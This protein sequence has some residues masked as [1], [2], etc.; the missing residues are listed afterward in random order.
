MFSTWVVNKRALHTGK[1]LEHIKWAA[2]AVA[3]NETHVPSLLTF[4]SHRR[5]CPTDPVVASSMP[6]VIASSMPN[7]LAPVH[8]P[9]ACTY[10]CPST[11][12]LSS[13]VWMDE[14]LPPQQR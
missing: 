8:T 4:L 11:S 12:Y 1:T 2:I 9:H 13:A 5:T 7:F 6:S 14:S 3:I 10:T